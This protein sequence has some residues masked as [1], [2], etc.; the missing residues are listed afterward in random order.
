MVCCS[1]SYNEVINTSCCHSPTGSAYK[2][3][4]TKLGRRLG[5]TK[6]VARLD[7]HIGSKNILMG[8][9]DSCNRQFRTAFYLPLTGLWPAILLIAINLV[10]VRWLHG[11]S[12]DQHHMGH[13]FPQLHLRRSSASG[14]K[15]SCNSWAMWVVNV[16]GL[17]TPLPD[18]VFARRSPE[19]TSIHRS[20]K[21]MSVARATHSLYFWS[22]ISSHFRWVPSPDFCWISFPTRQH[23]SNLLVPVGVNQVSHG[24]YDQNYGSLCAASFPKQIEI[25]CGKPRNKSNN[26]KHHS[27]KLSVWVVAK[28][29]QQQLVNGN[30]K[31]RS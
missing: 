1:T 25:W 7:H 29:T 24:S 16:R 13:R 27:H 22:T 18:L 26:A 6:M 5:R 20:G 11:R 8:H 14:R 4:R 10:A 2:K 19:K 31:T 12:R 15:E 28:Q 9:G 17:P 3:K 23:G 21:C 30:W